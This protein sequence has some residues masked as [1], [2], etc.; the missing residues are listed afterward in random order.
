MLITA[1]LLLFQHDV[2]VQSVYAVPAFSTVAVTTSIQL[3]IPD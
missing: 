3:N 1:K 2:V